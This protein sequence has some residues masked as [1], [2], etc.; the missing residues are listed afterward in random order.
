MDAETFEVIILP[1]PPSITTLSRTIPVTDLP[2]LLQYYLRRH[3]RFKDCSSTESDNSTLTL[4][5]CDLN[6]YLAVGFGIQAYIFPG[7]KLSAQT[8]ELTDITIA[9]EDALTP[10]SPCTLSFIREN[11]A[12]QGKIFVSPVGQKEEK[13]WHGIARAAA[14]D[15]IM[16]IKKSTL[17]HAGAGLRFCVRLT[18][19]DDPIILQQTVC[20]TEAPSAPSPKKTKPATST[21]NS[22]SR[23]ARSAVS[24]SDHAQHKK[25]PAT[26]KQQSLSVKTN[27]KSY[28]RINPEFT[29]ESSPLKSAKTSTSFTVSR[30]PFTPSDQSDRTLLS[31]ITDDDARNA[32]NET[33]SYIALRTDVTDKPNVWKGHS[34]WRMPNIFA[35]ECPDGSHMPSIDVLPLDRLNIRQPGEPVVKSGPESPVKGLRAEYF[36]DANRVRRWEGLF[37]ASEI[38]KRLNDEDLGLAKSEWARRIKQERLRLRE[39]YNSLDGADDE[40]REMARKKTQS[41]ELL[42]RNDSS[43]G[44]E[45]T[46]SKLMHEFTTV[47]VS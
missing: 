36:S 16:G 39:Q 13:K 29:P 18:N 40:D 24:K 35:G 22:P 28:T 5:V 45:N 46:A 6:E 19:G 10:P 47:S 9:K 15:R 34:R 7:V 8:C 43:R 4:R 21:K 14:M 30:L 32:L 3:H 17:G 25:L 38:D 42:A 41:V 11:I 37:T 1:P 31:S 2:S 12:V 33:P 20:A 23:I 44:S 26:T 27:P